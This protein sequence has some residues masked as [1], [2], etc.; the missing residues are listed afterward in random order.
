MGEADL[1]I[2]AVDGTDWSLDNEETDLNFLEIRCGEQVIS[3]QW[4]DDSVFVPDYSCDEISFET[5]NVLTLGIHNLQFTFGNSIDHAHNDAQESPQHT[6]EIRVSQSTD[7]AE[8]QD[9][10]D[11]ELTS[12]DL[13][14]TQRKV[15]VR[16]QNVD[17]PQGSVITNAYIQFTAE[18]NN[19]RRS[20]GVDIFAEAIDDSPTFSST[21]DDISDRARTVGTVDWFIPS[22][23][24]DGDSGINQR[25]P[26]ISSLVQE[27]IDRDG[28]SS[29]NS[30]SFILLKNNRGDRDARTF[31]FNPINAPS[32]HVEYFDA[33]L[34]GSTT[35]D[36]N[37]DW[38]V[39][40]SSLSDG[41]HTIFATTLD[42]NNNDSSPSLPIT[43]EV[44]SQPNL[45]P[46]A[47][48]DSD[49]TLEDNP[50]TIDVLFNDS[51]S[52]G[53]L[54]T[55]TVQVTSG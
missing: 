48:D 31:N 12:G 28:W 49:S 55:T 52:D 17:I 39:E 21:D 54:D 25:T 13:D 38:S 23:V 7:D 9:D 22:W 15:G 29:D 10:G 42:E 24:K 18:D 2:T 3:S 27:V 8:E 14:F 11:M 4:I 1:T 26:D 20:T 37:G 45:P 36:E 16:F 30:M 34:I 43:Y 32:L 5:S 53:T 46:T 35:A 41:I 47:N 19:E 40:V 51:D 6:F 33:T 44:E 50:V